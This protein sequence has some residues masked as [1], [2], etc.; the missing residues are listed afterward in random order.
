M[1]KIEISE[2][3]INECINLV[4]HAEDNNPSMFENLPKELKQL[5]HKIYNLREIL[6]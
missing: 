5:I 4:N 1:K 6:K 2:R 3:W